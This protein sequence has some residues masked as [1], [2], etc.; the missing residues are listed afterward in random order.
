MSEEL[1]PLNSIFSFDNVF[2]CLR[3]CIILSFNWRQ[4]NVCLF[5]CKYQN[6]CSNLFEA[7]GVLSSKS[8]IRHCICQTCQVQKVCQNVRAVTESFYWKKKTWQPCMTEHVSL[9][10]RGK[11]NLSKLCCAV[12]YN[13][14]CICEKQQRTNTAAP[15]LHCK[16]H[17]LLST[18]LLK[19]WHSKYIISDQC[20]TKTKFYL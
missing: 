13:V 5:R 19:F 17:W 7:I 2:P 10:Q 1:I 20:H 15:Q 12:S 16:F 6:M 11:G 3:S 14:L 9:C 8:I 18:I 4:R